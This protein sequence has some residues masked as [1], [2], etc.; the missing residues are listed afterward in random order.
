MT[1]EEFADRLQRH[2]WHYNMSDDQ[3]VWQRGFRDDNEIRAIA[4]TTPK[5]ARMYDDAWFLHFD[6]ETFGTT[7]DKAPMISKGLYGLD[8]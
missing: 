1:R 7:R 5:F 3:S 4:Q 6:P 2:D 8:D